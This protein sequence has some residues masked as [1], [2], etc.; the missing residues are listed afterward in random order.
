MLTL[1]EHPQFRRECL[2]LMAR[3]ML[4]HGRYLTMYAAGGGNWLQVE[5]SGLACVAL[6]F[7]EFKLAPLFYDVA[8][9]RLVKVDR[10]SAR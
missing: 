7:P 1:C 6:L 3:S 5:S 4:D 8:M 9:K 10:I 2:F